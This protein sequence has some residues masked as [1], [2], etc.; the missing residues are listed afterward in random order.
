MLSK[1]FQTK[2][3]RYRFNF[4]LLQIGYNATPARM[5]NQWKGTRH[6]ITLQIYQKL[7]ETTSVKGNF[8]LRWKKT[9]W[10][11]EGKPQCARVIDRASQDDSVRRDRSDCNQR[12]VCVDAFNGHTKTCVRGVI[13]RVIN[14]Y[15]GC[16]YRTTK[17]HKGIFVHVLHREWLNSQATNCCHYQVFPLEN[18]HISP[19]W[20]NRRLQ[21]PTHI[22]RQPYAH[23]PYPHDRRIQHMVTSY[24]VPEL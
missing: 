18:P 17:H 7:P 23:S 10:R 13:N 16:I 21:P 4:S 6:H 20:N 19:G 15:S 8:L 1:R 22:A 3:F 2:R 24:D 14:I 5:I 9:H 12:C 11:Q